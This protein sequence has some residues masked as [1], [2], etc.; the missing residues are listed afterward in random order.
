MRK[1]S[2][3][4]E[5]HMKKKGDSF[6]CAIL[7]NGGIIISFQRKGGYQNVEVQDR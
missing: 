3:R 5:K 2:S 7:E 4:G 1:Q 6:I